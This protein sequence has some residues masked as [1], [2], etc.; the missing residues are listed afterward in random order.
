MKKRPHRILLIATLLVALI[1][2]TLFTFACTS[3]A[4]TGPVTYTISDPTGDWGYP[5][6]YLR[7]SR[8]P[9]HIR[10]SLIFD[11]LVWKDADGFIPALAED[12]EY[13]EADNAY[14]FHLQHGVTWHDGEPFTADD[15][16]FTVDYMK[17]HPD[18][19]VT[20][21]GPSGI[22]RSEIIDDYTIKL[23]LEQPYA[24]FLTDIANTMVILPQHVWDGVED[25][26]SL[27]GPE[28]VI[29][30]GPYTL[31]DYSKEH[32]TYLYEDYEDYYLGKPKVDRIIF[33]K[34]SDEMAAAALEQ[35]TVDA[36]SIPAD[37]AADMKD[38]GFDVILCPYGWNAKM[39]INHQKEPFSSRGFRQALAYAIDREELVQITQRGHAIAGS[40]GLLPPDSKW[41]NPDIEWYEYNTS[42]SL[43]LLE[44]LGY[45]LQNG[46]LMKGNEQLVVELI[47][48]TMYG[49]DEV[50]QF[51]QDALEDIGIAVDLQVM[52]GKTLDAKV[53]AWDF[54][55]SIYGHG[56]LYEPSIL[57]K[58]I[59]AG[60][61]NSARYTQN[62]TLNQVL[63]DQLHEMDP[64]A[65]LELVQQAQD[66]Y[67]KELPALTLY[68]PDWYW[69][70][71]GS[72]D[73]YYTYEGVASGIPIPLNKMAFMEYND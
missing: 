70:H 44:G 39:T 41:F 60:G 63:E 16:A 73:L 50:G 64:E 45:E 28:A 35:G 10:M 48:Q 65:R 42:R 33:T 56:G 26:M 43:R 29:G 68:H 25:P 59:T 15:V 49:F 24:P 31:A 67:A 11:T 72:V 37:L 20:L 40:P 8:G 1:S 2:V 57:P 12:W 32:G 17:I 55:L 23:Y 66:I 9:G 14:I 13:I 22:N 69:A 30:T 61:F 18:P 4:P 38:A 27:T 54:D 7:Y 34:V 36:A 51:I 52:E 5:S 21:V 6:P 71:D 58:V 46:K 47:T 3:T 62:A 19:F 53:E